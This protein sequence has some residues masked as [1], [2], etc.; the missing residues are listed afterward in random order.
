MLPALARL[1]IA[2]YTRP[3]ERILDPLSGIGTTGVEAVRLGRR[4]AGVE[5]EEAFVR[6]QREN[7]ESARRQG[8]PGAY[9][10]IRG[11]ARALD[12]C[13][14]ALPQA[15]GFDAVITS[16][17]YGD[18]LGS[19]RGLGS[20]PFQELVRQG[21]FHATAIPR[22]Y[23]AEEGNLGNLADAAYLRGMR[24]VWDGCFG[25][26]RPGELLLAVVQPCRSGRLL[27]PLHHET[28][29][30]CAE[31]GFELLDEVVA[32]LGRVEALPNGP[33]RLVSHASFWRRLNVRHLRGEGWPVTL[34]QAEYVL[35]L[36]KPGPAPL[37]Q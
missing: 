17:P 35:V 32:V 23:G 6:F 36:R 26:L 30:L 2:E 29:R 33:A 14:A 25:A 12:R 34:G 18:R 28:A 11:D 27:R 19:D 21:R 16:P 8:A 5:L 24:Q 13:L 1:L 15:D 9:R 7:L 37:P 10:V 4:Y 31:A 3:G 20:A 22:T